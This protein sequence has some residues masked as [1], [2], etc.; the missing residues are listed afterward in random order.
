[1]PQSTNNTLMPKNTQAERSDWR[2]KEMLLLQQV[3]QN[4]GKDNGAH[5]TAL[6]TMLQLMSELFGLNQGR[7][8]LQH[9][10]DENAAIAYS[11]G[12]SPEQVARGVYAPNEGITGTVLAHSYMIVVD[13]INQDPLFL[14]RTVKREELP[15]E[16]TMFIALPIA[17][18]NRT[19]GVLACHR[20]RFSTRALH[21]DVSLLRILATLVGQLLY[22]HENHQARTQVLQNQNQK[23]K[24]TL[25]SHSQRYGIVG[26]SAALLKAVGE[27]ERVTHSNANVLLL[28]ENGSG[29]EM[30][31]RTLHTAGRR[32]GFPFIKISRQ[33][34]DGADF[35]REIFGQGAQ[36]GLLEQADGGTV[37]FDEITDLNEQQQQRL[38]H[39]LQENAVR[40]E[41]HA[42]AIPVNAR[43]LTATRFN[44]SAEVEA[45]R[46]NADLYY[47]LFVVSIKIPSLR[48]RRSDIPELAAFFLHRFN[49]VHHRNV[50]LTGEAMQQLQHYNW[51]GNVSQLEHFIEQLVRTSAGNTAD[52]PQVWQLLSGLTDMPIKAAFP[53]PDPAKEAG[54]A[55]PKGFAL[56]GNQARPYLQAD[57][58]SL[59]KIEETLT[60]CRG[61]KTQA[62]Q[63]LGLSTRQL[64][65]RL[66]KLKKAQAAQ[67]EP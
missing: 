19:F 22:I 20:A 57:S 67:Q 4:L 62:A 49:S 46:F 15:Q 24:Q 61:N 14:G 54:G 18:H 55:K 29:K 45:G 36:P 23:L 35:D 16:K 8:V 48:E 39:V 25:Q 27:L 53:K 64:Y 21:D 1:M 5:A 12:M 51:P 30:F 6:K 34:I 60:Y 26:S 58:H 47:R 28:G 2:A 3:I 63:M 11:Y 17:A 43:I 41:D 65:Y 56:Q 32:A 52:G 40:R 9:T 44:L 31:A 33:D 50:N 7:I 13:D 10:E 42:E 38:L 59:E 37:F 66:E